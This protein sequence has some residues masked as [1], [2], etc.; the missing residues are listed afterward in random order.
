[1]A[2]IDYGIHDSCTM[3]HGKRMS[4]TALAAHGRDVVQSQAWLWRVSGK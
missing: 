1:M 2:F 4:V 3:L